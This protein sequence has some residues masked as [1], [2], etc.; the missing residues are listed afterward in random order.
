MFHTKRFIAGAALLLAAAQ[1]AQAEV[2]WAPELERG[3]G[4]GYNAKHYDRRVA[5]PKSILKNSRANRTVHREQRFYRNLGAKNRAT[6]THRGQIDRHKRMNK[7]YKSTLDRT[8][9]SATTR[10][11]VQATRNTHRAR[12]A[13][14]I[15][16]EMS[17]TSRRAS[18]AHSASRSAKHARTGARAAKSARQ[19]RNTAKVAR[20][21]SKLR[22]A[23]KIAGGG[24]IAA[25]GI[26][27]TEQ[28]LGVDVPDPFEAA[29]WTYGTLKDPKNAGRRFEKLGRD[30]AR[31]FDKGVR[32]LT[33]PKQM[34]RNIERSANKTAKSI[35]KMGKKVGKFFGL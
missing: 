16:H 8:G 25:A 10:T 20:H 9:R 31:E 14:R 29:E 19:A 7:R 34:G 5:Q 12:Q 17:H 4:A 18:H 1:G 6:M 24:V 32:T 35:N 27:A 2:R 13:T 11:P 23:R 26:Y 21:G 15:G 3:K 22:T 33:N 30:S 28:T